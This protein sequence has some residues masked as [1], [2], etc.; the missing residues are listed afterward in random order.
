MGFWAKRRL[1]FHF[2]RDHPQASMR[3]SAVGTGLSKSSGHRLW[4]ARERRDV[5]PESW[6]WATAE[7]RRWLVRLG[8]ASLY[9]FGCKRGVGADTI[10]ELFGRLGLEAQVGS[11]PSAVR[12]LL[13]V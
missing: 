10:S 7:G 11:A 5:Q 2:F 8:V 3:H 4:Q 1:I 13:E 6:L 9:I 12:G